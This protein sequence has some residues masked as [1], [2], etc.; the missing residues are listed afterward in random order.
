MGKVYVLRRLDSVV[1]KEFVVR[2]VKDALALIG[3]FEAVTAI[4]GLS[5][6]DILLFP[7][8]FAQRAIVCL[9][10]VAVISVICGVKRYFNSKNGVNIE[11]AG[12]EVKIVAD[13][14]FEQDGIKLI[15]FNEFF[16]TKVDDIVI[17]K[18][19]LN[20]QYVEHHANKQV[21]YQA[22]SSDTKSTLPGPVEVGGRKQYPLGTIKL[23][24]DYALLAFT[25]MDDLNRAFL[26]FEQYE[27]CLLNMWGELDRVYAGK[28]VVVPLLGSGITRFKGQKPSEDGLLRC[29]LC[30][31]SMSGRKF[32]SGVLI[33]LAKNSAARMRLY[34]I[35]DYAEIL[36]SCKNRAD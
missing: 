6:T 28:Q 27:Q 2:S 7:A 25:H 23:C 19:S 17:S 34:D 9:V 32:K 18:N 13:D 8:D 31:L 21:L 5:L 12:N 36:N 1:T 10:V 4:G 29:M 14:L 26:S 24:E 16:D 15:P 33:T 11:I 20:G 30:T 3:L 22:I 35:N